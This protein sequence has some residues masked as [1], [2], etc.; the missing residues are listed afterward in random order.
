VTVV[1]VDA[2]PDPRTKRPRGR[3]REYSPTEAVNAALRVFWRLGYATT[4]LDDLS[5][6]TGMNRPSLYRAFGD[7]RAIF[8]LAA[9]RY[10][11]LMRETLTGAFQGQE[12]LATDLQRLFDAVLQLYQPAPR[13]RL[14]LFHREYCGATGCIGSRFG[15]AALANA[16]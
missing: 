12:P 16:G 8:R 2:C 15:R 1:K 7:K 13:V 6:A 5:A 9:A 11:A 10:M 14:R 4:S 3:P